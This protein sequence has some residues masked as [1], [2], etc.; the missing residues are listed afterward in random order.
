MTEERKNEIV[1][2]VRKTL[3]YYLHEATNGDELLFKEVWEECDGQ[4]EYDTA[5]NEIFTILR[6]VEGLP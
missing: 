2:A 4:D 3:A 1:K 6:M 5:K